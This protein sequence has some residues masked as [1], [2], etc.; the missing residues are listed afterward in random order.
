MNTLV[1]FSGLPG[2]GKSTLA[3]RL[4]CEL[5]WPLRRIDDLLEPLPAGAD[6]PFWDAK[7]LNLLTVAEAQ[8]ELGINVIV[9][10]VFMKNDRLHAQELARQYNARFRPVHTFVSDEALWKKRV[11]ERDVIIGDRRIPVVYED[12][13]MIDTWE[14]LQY[15]RQG[16]QPWQ[17][18]TALFVDAIYPVEQNYES[19]LNYVTRENVE[20]KSM[21]IDVPLVKGNY[22]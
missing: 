5:Q 20:I 18:N 13:P 6:I 15:Q 17:P 8:L 7:I 4:A 21:P 14:R 2:T 1:I 3:N 16:F 12:K 9:D 22:H 10:S 19:V 11:T